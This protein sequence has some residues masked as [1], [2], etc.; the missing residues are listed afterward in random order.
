MPG[1]RGFGAKL[2]YDSGGAVFVLVAN[3][4]KIRPFSQKADVTDVSSMDSPSDYKE[5][6]PAMLDAGQCVVD[7]NYDDKAA[8]HIWLQTNL[9]LVKTFRVT[10]PGT[11]PKTITFSGFII[12]VGP[13]MPHD[14]KM[15]CSVTVEITSVLTFS[16]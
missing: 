5:K 11:L 10:G 16:A 4:T 2:E 9:G 13:E 3:I 12:G 15:T 14:N 7:L 6:L 8:S 1:K